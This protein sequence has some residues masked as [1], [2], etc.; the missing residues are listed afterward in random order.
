L[1]NASPH[2]RPYLDVAD[3]SKG[4]D[5]PVDDDH[6]AEKMDEAPID[7]TVRSKKKG[8]A[9]KGRADVATVPGGQLRIASALQ[10]TEIEN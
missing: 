10:R 3:D 1:V 4:I 8:R 2:A 6:A 5:P 7:R 9:A